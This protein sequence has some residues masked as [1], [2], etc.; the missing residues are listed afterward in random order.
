MDEGPLPLINFFDWLGSR[1]GRV[2]FSVTP[3]FCRFY[4]EGIALYFLYALAF[5]APFL[6][7]FNLD[8]TY[9]IYIYICVCVCVYVY[10]LSSWPRYLKEQQESESC[11]MECYFGYSRCGWCL[12]CTHCHIANRWSSVI[13]IIRKLRFHHIVEDELTMGTWAPFF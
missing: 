13:P 9:Q 6:I 2:V 10:T 7:Q 8:F 11:S 5:W 3:L 12:I 1:W 4:Y